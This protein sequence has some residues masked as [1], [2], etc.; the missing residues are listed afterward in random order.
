M[1]IGNRPKQTL[2]LN[3][4]HAIIAGCIVDAVALEDTFARPLVAAV[5][6]GLTYVE[7]ASVLMVDAVCA[8]ANA[9]AIYIR[10]RTSGVIVAIVTRRSAFAPC[11]ATLSFVNCVCAAIGDAIGLDAT[12]SCVYTTVRLGISTVCVVEPVIEIAILRSA[13]RIVRNYPTLVAV[14]SAAIDTEAGLGVSA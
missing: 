1:T 2:V 3:T 8:T 12:F 7:S 13:F 9:V 6:L 5:E 4:T 10:I 14:V 11:A